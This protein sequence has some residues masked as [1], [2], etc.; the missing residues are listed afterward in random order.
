MCPAWI[1]LCSVLFIYVSICRFVYIKQNVSLPKTQTIITVNGCTH[2][3]ISSFISIIL[4]ALVKCMCFAGT[5]L[6]SYETMCL[7]DEPLPGPSSECSTPK[8]LK[9]P[10]EVARLHTNESLSFEEAEEMFYIYN[11]RH[12]YQTH[13]VIIILLSPR[14]YHFIY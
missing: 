9:L 8:K 12:A 3:V 14:Q 4:G 10:K 13:Y 1:F 6:E 11:T 5:S 2:I 7:S